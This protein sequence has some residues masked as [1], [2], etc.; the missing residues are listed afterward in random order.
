[1]LEPRPPLRRGAIAA[2]GG[3]RSA[4]GDARRDD[5]GATALRAAS[6]WIEA[7][8][9]PTRRVARARRGRA[10][11]AVAAG[12][13]RRATAA[14]G[15]IAALGAFRLLCAHRRGPYGVSAWTARIEDWLG[16]RRLGAAGWYVGRPLLVTENDYGLRLYNG[17]TGV[18]VATGR[19]A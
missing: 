7:D 3:R 11:G 1:M 9:A 2:R 12:R 17:D 13:A 14:R 6:T 4:A 10:R 18:V 5:R 15:A 16:E 19:A 8:A